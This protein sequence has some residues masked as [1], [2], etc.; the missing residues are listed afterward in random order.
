VECSRSGVS[1]ST[2]QGAGFRTEDNTSY[3]YELGNFL[4]VKVMRKRLEEHGV[5]QPPRDGLGSHASW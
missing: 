1:S 3:M 4:F 5:V 2:F